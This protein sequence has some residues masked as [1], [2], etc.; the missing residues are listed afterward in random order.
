[1]LV[2]IKSKKAIT[3]FK[4]I[5]CLFLKYETKMTIILVQI[6]GA[7]SCL[8]CSVRVMQRGHASAHE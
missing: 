4:I 6:I 8:V 3:Y 2:K 1:M 7:C 5:F